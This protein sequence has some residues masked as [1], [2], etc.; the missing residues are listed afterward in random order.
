MMTAGTSTDADTIST[1]IQ[2]HIFD[3]GLSSALGLQTHATIGGG[4]ITL[5]R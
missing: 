1:I 4:H 2:E 3:I 5:D